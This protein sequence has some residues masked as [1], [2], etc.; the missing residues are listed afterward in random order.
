MTHTVNDIAKSKLFYF[1][2]LSV[3]LVCLFFAPLEIFLRLFSYGTDT[4]LF[5]NFD[6][7]VKEKYLMVNPHVG[8][9]YFNRLEA[10]T[11]TNDI[12][13][14]RKPE[15]AFRVFLLGS[16][17][18]YGFP[19]DHNLMASRILHK[20]LQD[21]YPEIKI[22]VVNTSITAINSITLRD[23]INQVLNHDPDAILI[24]AGHNE[25]YGAFGVGSNETMSRNPVLLWIHFKFMNL[26]TYQLFRSVIGGI[27]KL[28][29]NYSD[30][31]KETGT[32]MKRIVGDANIVFQ[33]K[34]YQAGVEQFNKN[35][36]YILKQAMKDDIP[37]FISDLIS[38][39][40]DLPPF[41]DVE[42][43]NPSP[44]MKYQ[45]A[46][47]TL[48][49][50]DTLQA[51]RLF[52]LAKDLDPVRFRASEEIN[53]I[54]YDLTEQYK[55]ILI[56]TKD[57][58]SNSS[59][60]G[61]IGDNLLT[62]HVHPNIEGQ[63]V[64]ADA[65]YSSIVASGTIAEAPDPNTTQ[66][67]EFY[68]HNWGYTV[69]DSLIG[70]YKIEHLKSYWP[71]TPLDANISFRDTFR[72]SG[73]VDS[74][75]F[76]ILTNPDATIQSLH[77]QL[78]EHYEKDQQ[79]VLARKEYDALISTNPYHS[80]YYN[81]AANC[82]LKSNDL[83]AGETYLKKSIQFRRTIFAYSLLGEIETIKHNYS[84]AIDLYDSALELTD[85]IPSEDEERTALI[86]DVQKK[87]S[88]T[89]SRSL[90][91]ITAQP[92]EYEKYVPHDIEH[93]Y[94]R[95]LSLSRSDPDSALHYYFVGLEINDCPLVN[96][97][98]GN[99]LYQIQDT[100]AIHFYEK[101]YD[102]FAKDPDFL[103]RYCVASFYN[104]ETA[105]AKTI[106]H[107]LSK[108]APH[109]SDLPALKEAIGL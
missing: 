42:G 86:R 52:Y 84:G 8:E 16:S 80:V 100:R 75:A 43:A 68:R 50:E 76:S 67:K 2:I 17:T 37:V 83:Y 99:I 85:A 24:Y 71:F 79:F 97:R 13:L 26:R 45:E 82:M 29:V 65:F 89:H 81:R 61:L 59:A 19:Y 36:S 4:H 44:D 20:R 93:I 104:Q 78:A 107:E 15:N 96:F 27:S 91:P 21:T 60:G 87:R 48:A 39:I 28:L 5:V 64:L 7:D 33:G 94:N 55:A 57:W 73:F 95:A 6:S 11:A 90:Q 23:Y 1:R 62:E 108:I 70:A 98:I 51:R 88:E 53:E 63:F 34:K 102:G 41:G 30:I 106:F 101:A 74:L 47:T 22:E 12:F 77:M 72:T 25:Y 14:K 40:K 58:F 54:I 31:H 9:K 35:L 105:K 103:V 49:D 92:L 32:L 109:H 38:N 18:L 69:L 46:I 56:P 10:T 66:S 3:L